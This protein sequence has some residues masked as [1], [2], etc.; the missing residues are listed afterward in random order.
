MEVGPLKVTMILCLAMQ[1]NSIF[2]AARF[3]DDLGGAG[4]RFKVA[5]QMMSFRFRKIIWIGKKVSALAP[6]KTCFFTAKVMLFE[7]T[8]HYSITEFVIWL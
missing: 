4:D 1:P 8:D 5:S 7:A 6:S 3:G 2:H